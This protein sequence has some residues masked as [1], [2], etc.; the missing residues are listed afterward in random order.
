MIRRIVNPTSTQRTPARVAELVSPDKIIFV[1]TISACINTLYFISA[2][3]MGILDVAVIGYF[4]FFVII[5]L[6]LGIAL[7]VAW[8]ERKNSTNQALLF[9]LLKSI[10]P[11]FSIPEKLKENVSALPD[12]KNSYSWKINIL[13]AISVLAD[14]FVFSTLISTVAYLIFG[15][16]LLYKFS[17]QLSLI[18]FASFVSILL[19]C[20]R[21]YNYDVHL[22]NRLTLRRK[23]LRLINECTC[24]SN[25][26]IKQ[27][28]LSNTQFTIG[29][30][31][32]AI[33]SSIIF[34]IISNFVFLEKTHLF[35]PNLLYILNIVQN[36]IHGYAILASLAVGFISFRIFRSIKLND[37]DWQLINSFINVIST[38]ILV[39]LLSKRFIVLAATLFSIPIS[40]SQIA[41]ANFL[42]PV[43]ATIMSLFHAYSFSSFYA[44]DRKLYLCIDELNNCAKRSSTLDGS[45]GQISENI[46][47]NEDQITTPNTAQQMT[48]GR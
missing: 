45:S 15:S 25:L 13:L 31:I 24:D 36:Y 37:P 10:K 11:G 33:A 7:F 42:I 27:Q 19:C 30:L 6:I 3:G 21:S 38:Y 18:L 2:L 12:D 41:L 48:H 29:L 22:T 4:N 46:T 47:S 14:I 20:F 16:S 39:I 26:S 40:A 23:G 17:F 1:T 5:L 34:L 32:A 44:D 28:S 43:I 9:D 35:S 8:L